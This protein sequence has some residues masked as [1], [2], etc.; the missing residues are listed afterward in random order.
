MII[1]YKQEESGC[2]FLDVFSIGFGKTKHLI[3]DCYVIPNIEIIFSH[4]K[5]I[6]C[7]HIDVQWNISGVCK[8]VEPAD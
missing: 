7:L 6:S 3:N 1:G 4:C 8:S 5:F 2:N